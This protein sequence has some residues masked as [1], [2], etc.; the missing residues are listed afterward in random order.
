MSR[1][2]SFE[3]SSQPSPS[4]S[5]T[6]GRKFCTRTS[7]LSTS[8]RATARPSGFFRSS[9][10]LRW[11][12]WARRKKTLTPLRKRLRARPVA[13]PERSAGRLDLD[14]VGAHVGEELD[15]RRPEQELGEG[16]DADAR[17][18]AERRALAHSTPL[19]M[20]VAAATTSPRWVVQVTR[21][22]VFRWAGSRSTIS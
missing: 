8:R 15:A 3:T 2:L 6:P 17:E 19:R 14:H 13:L 7:A 5:M 1:G 22:K 12:L 18:D 4:R 16:E 11:F 10:R 9:V 20:W 21:A